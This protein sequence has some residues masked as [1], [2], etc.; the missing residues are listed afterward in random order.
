MSLGVY[1]TKRGGGGDCDDQVGR[2]CYWYDEN[3]PPPPPEA[4]RVK[5]ARTQLIALLDS[6]GK[7]NPGDPWLVGQRIR[8]LTEAGRIPEALDVARSCG[9]AGAGGEA[10]WCDALRGFTLHMAGRY[11]E[12]DSTYG[13]ALR[14]M[15]PRER[16]QF[17]DMTV[18]L[19][20]A[21]VQQYRQLDCDHRPAYEDRLWFLARPLMG[22]KGNDARTEYFSR[23]TYAK[24]L[25]GSTSAHEAGFDADERELLLRYS[26]PRAWSR[27]VVRTEN[28]TG[29]SVVGHEPTPAGPYVPNSFISDN[30]ANS[31]SVN[32]RRGVKPI[33]GRYAPSYAT[34]MHALH[35][36]VAVFRRGD[37]ALVAVAYDAGRDSSLAGSALEAALVVTTG[38][39]RDTRS[40][41]LDKAPP[42][43]TMMVTH[44]WGPL[45]VSTEAWSME[46]QTAARGRYGA[47][48][49]YSVGAR[50]T[51]SDILLFH[52]YGDI[53]QTL[54]DALPHA[55][56]SMRVRADQKLG[57][58]WE[59]YGTN[60]NG[61]ELEVSVVVVP[62]NQADPNWFQRKLKALRFYKDAAPVSVTTK[63]VS[64]RGSSRTARAMTVDISTLKKGRYTVQ[65]DIDVAGQYVVHAERV[66]EVE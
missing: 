8:Y 7:A 65:L 6:A 53:P 38:E 57:F 48:P 36:Q 34:P 17:R 23:V 45:L 16:C 62:E 37:S 1:Q 43:G 5:D 63:D 4:L 33:R 50:V 39:E 66:I 15:T 9:T 51:L 25:E 11:A 13:V 61:E 42:Q 10:W 19:D 59:S 40:V 32:W 12:S 58:F 3:E 60:P 41:H 27:T 18:L 28:G 55:L 14:A 2:F 56:T 54:E 24:M 29:Y 30:P 64:A 20:D 44:R 31:D 22:T 35:H 46:R 26:W 52:P 21:Q 47:R 49:P